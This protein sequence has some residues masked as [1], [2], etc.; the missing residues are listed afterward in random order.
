[1]TPKTSIHLPSSIPAGEATRLACLVEQAG[2]NSVWLSE[3]LFFR[4][5]VPTAGAVAQATSRINI[6]FGV[7]TPYNRHPSLIAMDMAS[8]L[9]LAGDRVVMGLGA[10]VKARVDR[11]G[12]DYTKPLAAM[13]ESVEI[14]RGMLAGNSVT[15][16]G[17]VHSAIDLSL[18][19]PVTWGD[20][21]IYL[22][23]TG[24]R[25]LRQTGEIA[26]GLVMTIMSSTQHVEWATRISN[27]AA[28]EAGKPNPMPA[29][30]YMP[31]SVDDDSRMAIQSLKETVAFFI[32]RW[33]AIPTLAELFTKWG[34]LEQDELD[35]LAGRLNGGASPASV[36]PDSLVTE[37]CVA[38]TRAECIAK[39]EEL[40]E[41]GVTEVAFDI[42]KTGRG[43]GEFANEVIELTN[44]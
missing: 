6:G 18:D 20:V 15:V 22:A 34:P 1:V 24:P 33:A 13:K 16:A 5:A 38:G 21:P 26:D 41:A 11:T 44:T 32:Q 19:I 9:E 25:S 12:V 2:V 23:S 7:L 30:V 40:R 42:G 36:V 27:E 10:G 14:V 35:E 39:L 17:E 8:L 43:L 28:R 37:Y 31:L 3:D 4:G 29:V